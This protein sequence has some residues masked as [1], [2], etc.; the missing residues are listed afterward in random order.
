ME[1]KIMSEVQLDL[2]EIKEIFELMKK[3]IEILER[4][5]NTAYYEEKILDFYANKEENG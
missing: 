5:I 3:Y 2:K 4:E 1:G